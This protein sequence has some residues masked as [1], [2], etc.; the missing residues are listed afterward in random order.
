M[1]ILSATH[2]HSRCTVAAGGQPVTLLPRSLDRLLTPSVAAD[3]DSVDAAWRAFV[4]EHS[5]L[6]LHVARSVSTNHDDAM[7]AYTFVLEQLRADEFHRLREFAADPRSKL[8]TWLVVVVRRL[9][10]DLYRRRYGRNRGIE[11]NARRAVR[12]RLCDLVTE[13]LE[14]HNLPATHTSGG[15]ELAVRQAELYVALDDALLTLLP[16]DRLLLRLRFDDD[17]SAQEIA[18]LLEYPSPFHVYRRVNLLLGQL[19]IALE[20]RGIESALP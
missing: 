5:R 7:D 13:D 14:L 9:C 10:L 3:V 19:R 8:T 12:R 1:P 2:A 20:R 15:A 18:R 6:L 17:L 4:S 16:Q 11:S